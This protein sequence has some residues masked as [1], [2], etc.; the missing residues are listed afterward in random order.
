MLRIA[1]VLRSGG[2][3]TTKHVEVLAKQIRNNL[4]E[5]NILCLSDR[6]VK[7]V[8]TMQLYYHWPTWFAKMELFRPDIKGDLLYFDLD[9]VV[10]GNL[11]RLA[12]VT[13]LTVLRDFYRDGGRKP[14]GIGSGLM[15][16]PEECRGEVWDRWL[17]NCRR[18]IP[19]LSSRG[20]GDQAFLET[21][22]LGKADYWQDQVPEEVVSWKVHCKDGVPGRA[23]VVCF[24]GKPRPWQTEMFKGLYE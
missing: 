21:L 11:R 2:E 4:P 13:T 20:L 19:K 15:F 7:L 8:E 22:W 5:A 6:P 3:Y 14:E 18:E 9:T 16:L 24:H 12:D 10:L 17:T 1:L 23:R